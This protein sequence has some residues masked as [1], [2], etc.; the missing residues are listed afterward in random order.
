[1]CATRAEARF[2][3]SPQTV[4]R[5]TVERLGTIS[6]ATFFA[7][8]TAI[9]AAVLLVAACGA[10]GTASQEALTSPSAAATVAMTP[11]AVTS[12]PTLSP[13]PAVVK[14]TPIPGAADS[15]VVVKL[16][17]N[18]FAWSLKNIDAPAKKVWHIH[19]VRTGG[20]Y[21]PNNFTLASGPTSAE[22]IFH[23]PNLSLGAFT[24]DIP[25]LP[26]GSYEFYCTIDPSS[27][28]GTV[29]IR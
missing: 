25:A 11:V 26:A 9:G 18:G 3:A 19:I 7:R 22:W 10:P 13:T 2:A 21:P 6:R 27:M 5:G 15:G 1:M 4:H 24:F 20:N 8:L 12:A 16:A 29:T 14:I 28:H 17:T 23:S